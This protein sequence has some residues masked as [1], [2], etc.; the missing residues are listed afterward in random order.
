MKFFFVA[1]LFLACF[2]ACFAQ[3]PA[4][5]ALFSEAQ[6]AQQHGDLT[7]AVQKYEELIRVHPEVVAAH[8]NLGVV[9][10]SLER[11]DEAIAQYQFALSEAPGDPGLLLDLGLA[12]FKK[13]DW[14]GA[15]AQFAMLHQQSPQD[16][17]AAVL[18]AKC[19][20]ELGLE[21]AAIALL[22]PFEHD[23]ADDPEVEWTL[24]AAMVRTGQS[25][26]GVKRIQKVA[27]QTNKSEAYQLAANISLGLTLFDQA[28]KDAEA[29][30]RL[31][32]KAPKAHVVLGMVA[33]YA[34]DL[35][36]A[37]KE[38]EAALQL[39]PKDLQARSKLANV[40]YTQRKFA[41]ARQN[42]VRALTQ[43]PNFFG[44]RYQLALVKQ[45]EGDLNGALQD[46]QAVAKNA[47]NWMP[48]HVALSVLYAKL[49][50][51][52][53]GARERAIVDRL[54][55]DEEAQRA[56]SRLIS[57]ELQ[58]LLVSPQLPRQ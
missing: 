33:E 13:G 51:P 4:P 48:P 45:A 35:D 6:Q 56:Q 57:P 53:E 54:R 19:Q 14:A 5:E 40:E 16:L 43:D 47:P 24:G 42:L 41:S 52:E 10:S 3:E 28:K 25:A 27:E 30:L 8:A 9:Y 1:A 29:V 7:K 34:G 55:A 39:D 26:E 58:P 23:H 31:D 37:A 32:P 18:L 22:Q 49:K 36:T 11:Y 38:Y 20:T 15:G 12:Y 44:A 21:G 2:C 46:L 17:R 50:R